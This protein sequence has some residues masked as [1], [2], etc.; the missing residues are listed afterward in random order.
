MAIRQRH[1]QQ[2]S[3]KCVKCAQDKLQF[4]STKIIKKKNREK[5]HCDYTRVFPSIFLTAP[6]ARNCSK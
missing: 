4:E 6:P 3:T 5:N 2:Q 1:Y